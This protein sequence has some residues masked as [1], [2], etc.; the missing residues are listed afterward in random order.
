MGLSTSVRWSLCLG[1][2]GGL[3]ELVDWNRLWAVG[4]GEVA[5]WGGQ[6]ACMTIMDVVCADV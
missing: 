6:S 5:R 2:I 4:Y 1:V 3:L